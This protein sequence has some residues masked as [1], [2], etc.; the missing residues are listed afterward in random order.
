MRTGRTTSNQLQM[1]TGRSSPGLC[2]VMFVLGAFA[3]CLVLQMV[4][5]ADHY[6]L[7][8]KFGLRPRNVQSLLDF[9]PAGFLHLS[10][11]H[12]EENGLYLL[13]VGFFAACQGIGKLLAVTAVVLVT[14]SLAWWLFGPLDTYSVGASGVICGWIGY[15]LVGSRW[16]QGVSAR[17][18][19]SFSDGFI[20]PSVLRGRSLR[21]FAMR[22]R[23]PRVRSDRSVPFGMYWRNSPLVFS[24]EP[25]CQGLCGS[26]K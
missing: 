15:G 10:W 26:Q 8:L 20:Y 7:N 11:N 17:S 24:F 3:A 19:V 23:S 12:F 2:A 21:L 22:L 18:S 9:V 4:D 25:R 13:V 6:E 16:V 1:L 5:S 14:S